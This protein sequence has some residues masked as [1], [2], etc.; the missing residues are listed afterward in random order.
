MTSSG[1]S[2]QTKLQ[3]AL[4]VGSVHTYDQ[5]Y[6]DL[7]AKNNKFSD[8]DIDKGFKQGV[9]TCLSALA[10]SNR[11]ALPRRYRQAIQDLAKDE[12]IVITSAD[13][14]GGIVI[15]DKVAYT[16]KMHTLLSDDTTYKRVASGTG[17]KT[18]ETFTKE[19]RKILRRSERGKKLLHLLEES[20][21]P[22]VMRGSPKAHK[23]GTIE[24]KISVPRS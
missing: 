6:L 20:P 1:T 16:E 4:L 21:K 17:K 13:K 15:L 12:S 18:S 3:S 11:S 8:S 10:H 9:M 24:S 2:V 5:K 23:P 19:A 22:P 7:L 14:G